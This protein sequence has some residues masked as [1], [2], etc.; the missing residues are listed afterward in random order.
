MFAPEAAQWFGDRFVSLDLDCVIVGDLRSVWD[1][2]DDFV[3]WG[4][5]SPH[6]RYNASMIMMTAGS[7]PKV[8][9]TFDPTRSPRQSREA[10]Q[11][12][13]DQGW[14]STCLGHGERKFTTRDG[15][16]S[17]RNHVNRDHV[18]NPSARGQLPPGARV[19]FF[20]GQID[21]WVREVQE[22]YPWI[23]R[24]YNIGN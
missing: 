23:R 10:G 8:W 17:F 12:G 6:T 15:V 16:F 24:H 7:R 2:P 13:S 20:H 19:V 21:P 14:I 4:D 3:I 11:F 22:R 9:T 5:T 1:K 18:F